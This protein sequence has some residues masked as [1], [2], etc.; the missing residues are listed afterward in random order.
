MF[1]LA[2]KRNSFSRLW[3]V[4]ISDHSP[5]TFSRPRSRNCRNPPAL[6]DLTEH[7]LHRLLAK[8]VA[9]PAT[10]GPQLPPHPV[11]GGETGGYPSPGRR[12]RHVAVAGLVRCDEGVHSQGIELINCLRRVV[13]RVGGHFLGDRACVDDG[14]F[15]HGYALLLVRWLIGG[16]GHHY[17]LVSIVHHRL[18]VVCLLEVP[19]S[20]GPG[21]MRDSG[22][23]K[24]RRALSSGTPGWSRPPDWACSASA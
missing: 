10:L 23:V 22:S 4:Q 15:H 7:W 16:P 11:P 24:L 14:L 3:P 19:S 13:A 6:L 18:A 12:R 21:M 2:P 20:R 9:L 5:L 1:D 17:H 8:T